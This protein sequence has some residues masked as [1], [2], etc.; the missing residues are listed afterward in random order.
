MEQFTA[1]QG[2]G[3]GTGLGLQQA[4]TSAQASLSGTTTQQAHSAIDFQ[5]FMATHLGWG[6]EVRHAPQSPVLLQ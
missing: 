3:I 6:Q 1:A 2:S 4:D 5:T